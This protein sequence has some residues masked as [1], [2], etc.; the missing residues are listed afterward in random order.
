MKISQVKLKRFRNFYDSTINLDLKTLIIGANDVGKTNLLYALRLLLD[1]TLSEADIEPKDSDF[2]AYTSD[3]NE[4]SITLKFEGLTDNV[5]ARFKENVSEEGVLFLKYVAKRDPHSGKKEIE[6]YAGEEDSEEKLSL[7]QGRTY[8]RTLNIKYI[9]SNRDLISYIKREKKYLLQEAKEER[10][11]EEEEADNKVQ[12]A[13]Q[14]KLEEINQE[15]SKLHYMK[16]ATDG[17]NA[18]LGELSF[19]HESQEVIFEVGSYE[20]TTFIEGA[21][22]ASRINGRHLAI[23]GDGR[24]N[25]IF[26]SLWASKNKMDEDTPTETVIFAIEEP[27]AHLHPHQQ[28]R[29]AEYLSNNLSSQVLLTSHSPQIACKFAPSSIVRLHS[30][31]LRT[32]A[33]SEG[34][35]PSITNAFIDFGHR[36]D[37]IASEVFFADVVFLVEG[38]SEILFYRALAEELGIDLDRYNISILMADGVGFESYIAILDKLEID[39]VLRTDNDVFKIPR[40]NPATYRLAGVERAFGFLLKY[41]E[42][43]TDNITDEDREYYEEVIDLIDERGDLRGFAEDNI[44]DLLDD[45]VEA[46]TKFRDHLKR[47]DFFI[48]DKDLEQDLIDSPISEHIESFIEEYQDSKDVADPLKAMQKN[49]ATFM[50]HFLLKH[51]DKLVELEGHSITEPLLRCVEL[52]ESRADEEE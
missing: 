16:K 29:L 18:E 51:K 31:N 12:D 22:L 23:G 11:P 1:R 52:A 27:E 50:Y 36:L 32:S 3:V 4:F 48:A 38:Q 34:C 39:F 24:N 25:Q 14:E 21:H 19:H 28:R 15:I 42:I 46:M 37:V 8:L 41:L 10:K 40:S 5:R 26:L 6:V 33:A 17:I 45:T 9:G 44:D 47:F 30:K 13:I 2:F 20:P 7:L 49:K 35:S 43:D